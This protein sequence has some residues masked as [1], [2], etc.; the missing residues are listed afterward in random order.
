MLC[1]VALQVVRVVPQLQTTAGWGTI[2]RRTKKRH[3]KEP[4]TWRKGHSSK[5]KQCLGFRKQV[6]YTAISKNVGEN[7]ECQLSNGDC[8]TEKKC[9]Y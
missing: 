7:D 5:D 2:S 8:T 4:F 3:F 9:G 1:R 6:R